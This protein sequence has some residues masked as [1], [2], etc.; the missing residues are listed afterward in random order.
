MEKLILESSIGIFDSGEVNIGSTSLPETTLN[1]PTPPAG[2]PAIIIDRY[3]S[4][5]PHIKAV[6]ALSLEANTEPI[7]LNY[8]SSDDVRLA[9]GGGNVCIGALTAQNVTSDSDL[10]IK[11]MIYNSGWTTPTLLNSWTNYGGDYSTIG[12]FRDRSGIVHLK[13]M[14]VPGTFGE[15]FP[16]F[17]LPTGF[18]PEYRLPYKGC[19]NNNT[20]R[21]DI[22][23]NGDVCAI[24]GDT[25]I[26][27]NGIFF[28]ASGY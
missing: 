15:S 22:L 12:Y 24:T 23:Q 28:R 4:T 11:G 9:Y 17:T 20:N 8:Y 21:I 19:S 16:I 26:S 7:V 6:E 2:M 10:T 3:D 18:R 14:M 27:L 5:I 1:I 13:G 25:W